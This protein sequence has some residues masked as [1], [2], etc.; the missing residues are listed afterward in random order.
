MY[1]YLLPVRIAFLSNKLSGI[2]QFTGSFSGISD[3]GNYYIVKV[4]QACFNQ[5]DNRFSL[6]IL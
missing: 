4:K 5:L 6:P 2:A 3:R 1:Y